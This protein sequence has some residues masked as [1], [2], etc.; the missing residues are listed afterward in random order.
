MNAKCYQYWRGAYIDSVSE[1]SCSER[2]CWL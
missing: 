1:F 2:R